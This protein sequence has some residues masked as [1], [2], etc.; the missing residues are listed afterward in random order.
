MKQSVIPT[1]LFVAALLCLGLSQ[2]CVTTQEEGP[3][4]EG[5]L[6]W[7]LAKLEEAFQA[8]KE[9]QLARDASLE[10]RVIR[11]ER[12]VREL[13]GSGG[14]PIARIGEDEANAKDYH[15]AEPPDDPERE[16]A[17]SANAPALYSQALTMTRSGKTEEGRKFFHKFL[18]EEP[19]SPYAPNAL[20]W[21]GE[22]YYRDGDYAR[23]ILSFKEV[24]A[25]FPK[26]DKAP[27][28]LLKM[29]YAYEHLG[30]M[31][32]ARF[33]LENLVKSYPDS[34]PSGLARKRL[35]NLGG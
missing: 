27:A 14:V 23:S 3:R 34:E 10:E 20:Y 33:Y 25:R 7:R 22:T 13:S 19:K 24:T 17:P 8:S 2:G 21:L 1:L 35:Q 28:A 32:N 18:E 26:S 29:G 15:V 16:G 12:R 4:A 30:D 6:E 31:D 11:L 5:S 9:E